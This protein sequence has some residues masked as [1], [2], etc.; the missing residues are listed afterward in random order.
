M[1][2]DAKRCLDW[3]FSEV[4]L[5]NVTRIVKFGPSCETRDGRYQVVELSD[6][7]YFLAIGAIRLVLRHPLPI[8]PG[9]NVTIHRYND[10]SELQRAWEDCEDSF[11]SSG[12]HESAT[13][14]R[15]AWASWAESLVAS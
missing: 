15:A 7:E 10:L 2:R 6:S 5:M 12:D 14:M 13:N 1:R 9:E 8:E 4:A 3:S 11:E